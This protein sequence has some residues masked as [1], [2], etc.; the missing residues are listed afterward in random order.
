M[1]NRTLQSLIVHVFLFGC[2]TVS[3]AWAGLAFFY[4]DGSMWVP[5]ANGFIWLVS[6]C[7]AVLCYRALR[8]IAP[9]LAHFGDC[10]KTC[11]TSARY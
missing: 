1:Q 6:L 5:I 10:Q 7:G 2:S 4:S 8:V 3:L 9:G 11:G